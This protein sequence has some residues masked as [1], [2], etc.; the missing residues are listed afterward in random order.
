MKHCSLTTEYWITG[1]P[2]SA[3]S[4]SLKRGF[5][6]A[7]TKQ[8]ACLSI[9]IVAL[10][11]D[12]QRVVAGEHAQSILD[13]ITD[14]TATSY[15]RIAGRLDSVTGRTF[16]ARPVGLSIPGVWDKLRELDVGNAVACNK[17][18]FYDGTWGSISDA[19]ACLK[20]QSKEHV[21]RMLTSLKAA[22]ADA[23]GDIAGY[24]SANTGASL[25]WDEV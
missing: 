12:E 13:S 16:N 1:N 20:E 7:R 24:I 14:G 6:M 9:G 17:G 25:T 15:A 23:F 5:N 22:D 11:N 18:D 19:I 2:H 3:V 10:E 8:S 21:E 4:H